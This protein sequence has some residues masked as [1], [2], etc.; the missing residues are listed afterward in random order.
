MPEQM[1]IKEFGK[2][3]N[4]EQHKKNSKTAQEIIDEL[5]LHSERKTIKMEEQ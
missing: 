4:K 2:A 5:E 1:K 3:W